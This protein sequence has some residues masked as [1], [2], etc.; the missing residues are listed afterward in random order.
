MGTSVGVSDVM[1]TER[2]CERGHGD[3]GY[4][5]T[6]RG[7]P[8]AGMGERER[9]RIT[10]NSSK[11]IG[12]GHALADAAR[13]T[14][15]YS[16]INTG[17]FPLTTSTSAP[18]ASTDSRTGWLV[19]TSRNF[20]LGGIAGAV[21]AYVTYPINFVKMQLQYQRRSVHGAAAPPRYRNTGDCVRQVLRARG[22]SGFF[23]GVLPQL[24]G[25]TP[26]KAIKLATNDGVRSALSPYVTATAAATASR[27]DG[28]GSPVATAQLLVDVVAGGCG[29]ASQV[30]F[31]NVGELLM[32]RMALQRELVASMGSSGAA[33]A[34]ARPKSMLTVVRELGVRQLYTGAG[35]CLARDASFAAIFFPLYYRLRDRFNATALSVMPQA[36]GGG[37]RLPSLPV[38]AAG[39]NDDN[40]NNNNN[41]NRDS[42]S[43]TTDVTAALNNHAALDHHAAL[44]TTLRGSLPAGVVA[45]SVAAGLTT[46]FDVVKTVMQAERDKSEPAFRSMLECARHLRREEGWRG[47]WKGFGPRVARSA[48]Q[49]GVTLLAYEL[50]QILWH[51]VFIS[52]ANGDDGMDYGELASESG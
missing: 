4:A 47:F 11:R 51:R 34:A 48:P 26:E 28:G 8:R 3:P 37:A 18:A 39:D 23:R 19:H 27:T 16:P 12:L 9:E 10:E 41:N 29:G 22:L 5:R 33:A 38:N 24:L 6:H 7:A 13:A 25:V 44:G 20:F 17:A 49:F 50:L 45:G 43:A 21:G 30:I 2:G 35:P 15:L 36:A 42:E 14:G 31:T 46:P 40:N 52:D 1:G 32:V